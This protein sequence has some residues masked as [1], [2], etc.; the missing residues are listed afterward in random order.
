MNA[1]IWPFLLWLARVDVMSLDLVDLSPFQDRFAG[2]LSAVNPY[3][4]TPLRSS[5]MPMRPYRKWQG[6]SGILGH[7]LKDFG[8]IGRPL[9]PHRAAGASASRSRPQA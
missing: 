3:L 7:L 1:S 2:E 9:A 6:F 5:M 8:V 4:I